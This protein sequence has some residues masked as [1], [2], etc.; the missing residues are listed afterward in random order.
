MFHGL[1]GVVSAVGLAA[2]LVLCGCGHGS[3]AGGAPPEP[4]P[5][6]NA[7]LSALTRGD[8]DEAEDAFEAALEIDPGE[9]YALTG[10]GFVHRRSG[11]PSDAREA[12]AAVLVLEPP[13]AG[14]PWIGTNGKSRPI[15][16]VAG[17]QLDVL[18]S[19]GDEEL[20]SAN[21]PI[22]AIG[23]DSN[24]LARFTALRTL[25]DQA[26][27]TGAEYAERRRA[28]LGALLARTRPPPA[29]RLD[30]PVPPEREL[31]ARLRAIGRLYQA[32]AMTAAEHTRE[33]LQ[34]L[35]ALMPLRHGGPDT[36]RAPAL[37]AAQL[38]QLERLGFLSKDEMK[39]ELEAAEDS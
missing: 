12:F 24:V 10:L 31:A 8:L 22:L 17:E 28:N 2:A 27:I 39:A 18:D 13:P 35:D 29:V 33:R 4:T 34:I 3:D 7:G 11:R 30:Q 6:V 15:L 23:P 1:S 19:D 16:A 5:H 37:G 38:E 32:G 21:D 36:P 20:L 14:R 26:L 25:Y 9:P